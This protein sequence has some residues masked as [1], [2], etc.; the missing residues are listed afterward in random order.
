MKKKIINIPIYQCKL[1]L[2]L[3]PDL[4]YIE[5]V[6][7]TRSLSDYASVTYRVS[8][9]DY[10]IALTSKEDIRAVVH[11]LIHVKN[12]IYED[13]SMIVD[14]VNDEHEAYLVDWLFTEIEKFLN[15][16]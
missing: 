9:S 4:S 6:Y 14:V 3:L 2:L 16:N 7:N 5:K 15:K 13:C 1:T 8:N 12:Y 11:E 10:I